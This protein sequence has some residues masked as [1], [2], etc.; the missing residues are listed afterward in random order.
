MAGQGKCLCIH[1]LDG[2]ETYKI[3][4]DTIGVRPIWYEVDQR[5]PPSMRDIL[6]YA[7]GEIHVGWDEAVQPE[8]EPSFCISLRDSRSCMILEGVTH[9]TLLPKKPG[10]GS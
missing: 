10:E 9:W 5:R 3:D 7:E 1:A 8:E 2:F 4:I 6:L